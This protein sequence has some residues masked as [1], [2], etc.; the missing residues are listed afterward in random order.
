MLEI[1]NFFSKLFW[2]KIQGPSDCN[3]RGMHVLSSKILGYQNVNSP[4]ISLIS[5]CMCILDLHQGMLKLQ[6]GKKERKM[7]WRLKGKERKRR[8]EHKLTWKIGKTWER[9][10]LISITSFS[11][12]FELG[13]MKPGPRS[14]RS[15]LS[16]VPSEWS[17]T[18]QHSP[19]L[20]INQRGTERERER[21]FHFDLAMHCIFMGPYIHEELIEWEYL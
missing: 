7:S 6:M 18:R 8:T 5:I 11:C 9:R 15:C 19:Q 20:C 4:Q 17:R 13:G 3:F 2:Y 16:K 10:K 12:I 14:F 21:L 1:N